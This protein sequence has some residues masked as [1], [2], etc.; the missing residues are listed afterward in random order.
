[1][2]TL[3]KQVQGFVRGQATGGRNGL[4]LVM[5]CVDHMFEHN[6][7][8]PLA[9]LIAKSDARDSSI[10]RGIAGQVAGGLTM[11]TKGKEAVKQPSG[12]FI[13]MG[14]NA[15]VT[16]KMPILRKLVEDGESFRGKAVRE[17]LFQKEDK[18]ANI[19]NYAKAMLRKID[20][21]VWTLAQVLNAVNEQTAEQTQKAA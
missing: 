3:I 15:G 20:K 14:N 16:D 1:M 4:A 11:S 7:W 13:K 12:M 2:A 17:H 19:N 6:D 8:T 10:L 18:P 9:W 5:A 21:E